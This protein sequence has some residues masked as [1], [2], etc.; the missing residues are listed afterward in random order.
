MLMTA[1]QCARL[2]EMGLTL[3]RR[4]IAGQVRPV[5]K[6]Y[7]PDAAGT[8]LLAWLSPHDPDVAYGLCNLGNG[9]PE[10]GGVRLSETAAMRG[11]TG[12]PVERDPTFTARQSL[13][14]YA[15]DAHTR[16][17]WSHDRTLAHLGRCWP[18]GDEAGGL[19]GPCPCPVHQSV[20]AAWQGDG[21]MP[22]TPR[23][24]N[25]EPT[26]NIALA[27]VLRNKHPLWREHLGAEQTGIFFGQPGLKPDILIRI[28]DMQPVVLE[29]E[30][31]PAHGVEED[32]RGRLGLVPM[33]AA[34]CVEQVVAVRMPTDLRHGQDDLVDHVAAVEYDYCL[35][36]GD[37]ASPH[38][39]PRAGWLSGSVDDIVR[40]IEHA[41]A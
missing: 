3:A 31:A 8:W 20:D 17:G 33:D 25:T 38:R 1:E 16:A 10:I 28:P 11:P 24:R 36:T 35:L 30:F 40:C 22:A 32:A 4:D 23:P 21:L 9:F 13:I 34:T 26:V 29:T 12:R 2:R 6:L 27:Q 39:W 19:D 5:V 7:T 41:I 14:D 18:I 37:P 15:M